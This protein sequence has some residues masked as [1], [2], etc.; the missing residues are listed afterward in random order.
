MRYKLAIMVNIVLFLAV[1][2]VFVA[3]DAVVSAVYAVMCVFWS[4]DSLFPIFPTYAK[5]WDF[6]YP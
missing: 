6:Y 4:T 3:V 1:D 5:P 2:A